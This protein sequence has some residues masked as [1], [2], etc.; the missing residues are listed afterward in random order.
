MMCADASRR[1]TMRAATSDDAPAILAFL[2]RCT[3]AYLGGE[4]ANEEEVDE[5]LH[6]PDSDPALD[7]LLIGDPDGEVVAF[8][9][10]FT[11]PPHEDVRCFA[12][13]DPDRTGQGI[14]SAALVWAIGRA[15]SLAKRRPAGALP[16]LHV[17]QWARDEAAG[18]LLRGHGFQPVRYMML[19][20]IDLEHAPRTKSPPHTVSIRNCRAD[21]EPQLVTV[22]DEA[23]A[24]HWGRTTL[25]RGRWLRE[26]TEDGRYEP[27][28]WRIAVADDQVVGFA[29]SQPNM[30]EEA[31]TGYV[32]DVGVIPSWRGRGLGLALLSDVFAALRRRGVPRA[33]LHVDA[34]NTTGAVRLYTRAGMR[35]E[36]SL[37]IWELELDLPGAD[38]SSGG[39]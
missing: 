11:V 22:Y 28:L 4:R 3:R 31:G 14:G 24:S 36:P 25:D 26:R 8:A 30:P 12:R 38:G 34:E 32:Q 35:P 19:M 21:D 5:R 1:F 27:D 17:T 10:I 13:V 9:H 23:F 7:T 33:A 20:R 39:C 18:P 29:L 15:A 37:V 6:E 2:R 16:V